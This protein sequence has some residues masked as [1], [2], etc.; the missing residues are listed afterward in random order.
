ML[1]T[2]EI[3]HLGQICNDTFGY[4][5]SLNSRV[6]T[7]SIK[8]SLQD[9]KMIVTYTTIVHLVSDRNLRDQCRR[10]EE[11]SI[12]LT[13]E[14]VGNLKSEFR[15]M[16]GRSL[17]SKEVSTNDSIEVISASPYSPKRTAYYRRFTTYEVE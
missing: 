5:G 12:K 1:S 14:H 13:K 17:K 4:A 11:E 3:S 10:F 16:A 15:S 2:S 9:N 6:P 7:S 8:T